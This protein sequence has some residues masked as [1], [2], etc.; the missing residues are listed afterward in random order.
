MRQLRALPCRLNGPCGRSSPT[1]SASDGGGSA[2]HDA[3]PTADPT[4][5]PGSDNR[6]SPSPPGPSFRSTTVVLPRCSRSPS[7]VK[8]CPTATC[9]ALPARPSGTTPH[10]HR[11]NAPARPPT[12]RQLRIPDVQQ[13]LVCSK[14]LWKEWSSDGNPAVVSGR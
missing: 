5:G 6:G 10:R 8:I 14:L 2:Q 7:P 9:A 4:F 3:A 12:G 1:D 11:R 13:M